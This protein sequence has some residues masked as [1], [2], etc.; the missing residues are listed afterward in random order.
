VNAQHVGRRCVV[1][2]AGELDLATVPDLER[3]LQQ[4]IAEGAREVWTDLDATTF[5]DSSGVVCLLQTQ[6]ALAELKRHFAVICDPARPARRVLGLTGAA[7]QLELHPS[8]T[9]A[10]RAA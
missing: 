6:F 4:A 10:H 7:A 3:A 5:M 2:F 9:A 8:R 1:S